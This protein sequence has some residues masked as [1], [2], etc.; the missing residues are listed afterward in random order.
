MVVVQ[1]FFWDSVVYMQ[2]IAYF[3]AQSINRL[4]LIYSSNIVFE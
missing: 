2:F 1:L 4:S 3:Q